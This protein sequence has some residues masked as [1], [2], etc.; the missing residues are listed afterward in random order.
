MASSAAEYVDR[1]DERTWQE[2]VRP[3]AQALAQNAATTTSDSLKMAA[4]V[5]TTV[6]ILCVY[7]FIQIFAQGSMIRAV[8]G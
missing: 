8:K 1:S 6:P 2:H 7:P 3:V 5:V 4:V